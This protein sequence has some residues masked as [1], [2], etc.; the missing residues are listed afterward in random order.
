MRATNKSQWWQRAERRKTGSQEPTGKLGGPHHRSALEDSLCTAEGPQGHQL[1]GQRGW[2]GTRCCSISSSEVD[3]ATSCLA[4]SSPRNI[5]KW[6]AMS[7]VFPGYLGWRKRSGKG[8][9][10]EDSN[11]LDATIPIANTRFSGHSKPHVAPDTRDI[12][13]HEGEKDK[14]MI[15]IILSPGLDSERDRFQQSDVEPNEG[16]YA[17]GV[18]DQGHDRR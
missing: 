3:P 1:L 11:A 8:S 6:F 17:E 16:R 10:Q 14:S 9:R 5:L 15:I 13:R 7:W 18:G 12:P 4:E 2:V